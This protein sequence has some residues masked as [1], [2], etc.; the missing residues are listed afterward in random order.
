M[1]QSILPEASF[2]LNVLSL[3]AP[4]CLCVSLC[5]NLFFVRT[6]TQD[7]F[8]LW[9]PN[10]AHMWKRPWFRSLLLITSKSCLFVSLL[11]LWNI[12]ET[13]KNGWNGSV[14][15]NLNGC[16]HICSP[17][18]SCHGSWNSRVVWTVICHFTRVIVQTDLRMRDTLPNLTLSQVSSQSIRVV[19]DA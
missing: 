3:L 8:K 18:G 12:C 4:L 6:I 15:H 13:C 7:P 9:S 14:F 1:Y 5:V 16:V 2:G 10:L 19:I 11:H 17:T